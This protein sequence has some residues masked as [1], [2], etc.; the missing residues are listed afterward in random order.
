[1]AAWL[2]SQEAGRPGT[3]PVV[4]HAQ[5]LALY[6]AILAEDPDLPHR[7]AVLFNAG[8]L[9]ADAGD[10]AAGGYFT[11]LL[12][13][14]PASAYVQ[15]ASLR[16]GDLAFDAQ[17]LG[18]G[19]THYQ[20]AAE[21][22]DPSLRAI[23]LYKTGW[24]HYNAD[25]FE[26]A[27][28]AFRGVLDLYAG[29]ARLAVQADIEHEAEQYFVF[30]LA[31]AGGAAAYERAFPE[32]ARDQ[33]Y[34]R[35]V[36]RAMGQHFRRYGE[37]ADAATVDRL[38]LKRW[39][40]DPAALDVVGRLA[41][42]Q[43]R[44][45]RPAEERATR[46]E[47]AEKFAPGGTW[48]QAQASDSL[49]DAGAEFARSAWRDEAFDH[50]RQARTSGAKEEWRAALRHYERLLERWPG[51]SAAAVYELYAGEAS[52]ELGDYR[53]SLEHYRRAAAA[54]RD[55]VAARASWQQ[56][57]ITDR[58]Y[59][60]TRPAAPAKGAIRGA[61]SDTLARAVIA[62]VEELLKRE[63]RHP[64]AADLVWRENQLAM[65]HGWND[66]ALAGLERFA[67]Q[68]PDDRRAPL[69]A[70]ERA[71]VHFRVG[72]FHAAGEAFAEAAAVARRAGADSLA[73]RAERALPVCA[74]REAEAAV[75]ADSTKHARHAELFARV[76]ERWPAYEHAATAQYRAGL[77][78]F[79]AGRTDDGAKA[80]QALTT[81][82]PDQPLARDARL[83]SAQAFEADRQPEKAAT[84][85]LEFSVKHPKDPDADEAWLRAIDLA[86]S[87]GRTARADELRGEY[88]DRWPADEE[89]A[90]ELLEVLAK[91]EFAALP[92]G[93]SVTTLLA[94]PKPARAGTATGPAPY[95]AQYLKRVAKQPARAS[96]PLL[97]EFRFRHGE[98]VFQ[99]YSSA[100]LTQPLPPSIAAKQR[101]LDS[102]LVRYRRTV[103]M[104]APEWAH[105]ATFRIGEALVGFGEA[106]EQSERPA[107]L[108]GDDLKAYD[109]VLLEQSLSFHD[110]GES[111]W[112]ELLQRNPGVADAWTTRARTALWGRLGDRFLFRAESDFPVVPG[113]G[114]GRAKAPRAD[115]A[116]ESLRTKP[117][118]GE[119]D[120]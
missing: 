72:D 13:E 58:W 80:M 70:S 22:A 11:R 33:P 61:G 92:Q 36:L 88:L 95:F 57:A 9:L 84:A 91:H 28:E 59:E 35:R 15:E 2:R 90:L 52:G 116:P 46:L 19:V 20:R 5:P 31:A 102:V 18:D 105:A 75:A 14:H 81:R 55:S 39:P 93:R 21:G 104:G 115:A 78:W 44:A 110:R 45:E 7:D 38:Y 49:K 42:T 112:T 73:R 60:S 117:I 56:V 71:A 32:G 111:V 17:Q 69:A 51:D 63:P 74:W 40:S 4:D 48:A 79:A 53:G 43:Q 1:M 12:T 108:T 68:F 94:R 100:R 120:R 37:F 87:A 27:A 54:G 47:W 114:P 30:S 89:V 41:E 85:W 62:A 76:A 97:A 77:A 3:L 24:A 82:W 29:D 50:H 103:D 25:R 99:L 113:G 118:A 96:K 10:P 34:A 65:L 26:A 106:L 64:Q 98:E 67:R 6:R 66:E 109:N 86:D 119:D 16:L 83:R 8:M 101:L 107:D 23:A